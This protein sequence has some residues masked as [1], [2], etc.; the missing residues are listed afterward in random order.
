MVICSIPNTYMP[1]TYTYPFEYQL[2]PDLPGV[3][4][5]EDYSGGLVRDLTCRI[6]YKL[7]ATLDVNGFFAKDLKANYHLTVHEQLTQ[8]I[9]PGHDS[10]SQSVNFLCCFN[11]GTCHLDVTMDKNVYLAGETAQVYCKIN[12]GSQVDITNMRCKLVQA[13]TF[14]AHGHNETFTRELCR[15]TFPGVPAGAVMEQPQPLPLVPNV[16]EKAII[17]PSTSGLLITCSYH[18]D[19]ECNIPWCPDVRLRLPLTVIAPM[20]V[21]APIPAKLFPEPM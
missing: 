18:V 3:F 20:L 21:K 19:V 4:E 10:T 15:Q 6:S 8:T 9:Q 7:K 5:I 13:I 16:H 12:N 1:G 2:P 11:K 14:K 17:N